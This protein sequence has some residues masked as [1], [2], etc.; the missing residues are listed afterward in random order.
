M[1]IVLTSAAPG[2]EFVSVPTVGR[3]AALFLLPPP[4]VTAST[5]PIAASTTTPPTIA[6]TFGS[7]CRRRT[8]PFDWT[9]GGAEAARRICLLFLPLGIGRKSSRVVVATGNGKS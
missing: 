9:G 6:S 2:S 4:S 7:A 5:I 3:P 8:P 1:N